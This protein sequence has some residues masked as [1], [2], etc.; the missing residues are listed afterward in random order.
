MTQNQQP[1]A[2]GGFKNPPRQP[3]KGRP[4]EAEKRKKT[5]VEQRQDAAKKKRKGKLDEETS[6]PPNKKKK[7]TKKTRCPFCFG[8]HHV[9]DC[10]V[11]K[12]TKVQEAT[13]AQGAT[14]QQE[15]MP[16]DVELDLRL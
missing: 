4:T 10:L 14:I 3:K 1:P 11:L 8:D 2:Q 6:E 7:A 12:A 13:M 5:L 16:P 15:N 9:S